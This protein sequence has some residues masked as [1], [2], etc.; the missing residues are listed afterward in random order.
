LNFFVILTFFAS[1]RLE[2]GEPMSFQKQ[3]KVDL[4]LRFQLAF[5]FVDFNEEATLFGFQKI[6]GVDGAVANA[7]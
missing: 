6:M 2:A 1:Q 3:D 7:C 4:L 5:Y